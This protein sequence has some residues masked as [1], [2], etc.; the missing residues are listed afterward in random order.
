MYS[1]T[2]DSLP[3][4]LVYALF[5]TIS[6]PLDSTSGPSFCHAVS[7][8]VMDENATERKVRAKQVVRRLHTVV[9]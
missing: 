1:V 6:P 8:N 7:R 9:L 4:S 2:H 3:R 5:N